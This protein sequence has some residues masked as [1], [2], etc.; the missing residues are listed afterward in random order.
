MEQRVLLSILVALLPLVLQS[1]GLGVLHLVLQSIALVRLL[2]VLVLQIRVLL[3]RGLV[4][5]SKQCGYATSAPRI[6]VVLSRRCRQKLLRT[7]IG[8][9]ENIRFT[10]I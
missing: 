3:A 1:M 10:S 5:R 2:V 9:G 7:G 4:M 6:S 8:E